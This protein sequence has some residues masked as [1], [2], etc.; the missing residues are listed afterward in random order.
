[1]LTVDID[2]DW[3]HIREREETERFLCKNGRSPHHADVLASVLMGCE[4]KG[5]DAV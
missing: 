5:L 1:M 3:F 4:R 2:P